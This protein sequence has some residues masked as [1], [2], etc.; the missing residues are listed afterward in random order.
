MNGVEKCV[1]APA[2]VAISPIAIKVEAVISAISSQG[3]R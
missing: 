3:A 1:P 2:P